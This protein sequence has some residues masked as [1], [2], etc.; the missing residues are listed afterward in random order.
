MRSLRGRA[1]KPSNSDLGRIRGRWYAHPIYRGCVGHW[2]LAAGAGGGRAPDFS[3]RANHGNLVASPTWT[4]A[5]KFGVG[6]SLDGTSQ[7]IDMPSNF[8]SLR[9]TN[10]FSVSAWLKTNTLTPNQGIVAKYNSA[11]TQRT[12][13]FR[14]TAQVFTIFWGDPADGTFEGRTDSDSNVIT[15][16]TEFYHVGFTFNSGVVVLYLNGRPTGQ[17][18]IAGAIPSTLFDSTTTW[19]VGIENETPP[20]D[21]AFNGI[22]DDV[23]IWNRELSGK[24]MLSMSYDPFLAYK[25]STEDI[26][27]NYFLLPSATVAPHYYYRARLS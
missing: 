5:A 26:R 7:S 14:L 1:F 15:S 12:L 8:Q 10:H 13:Y 2:M 20:I 17:S 27:N 9:I 16:T 3:G 25:K 23:R 4:R 22:L 18:Q 24:E 21:E 11:T 6:L 19:R